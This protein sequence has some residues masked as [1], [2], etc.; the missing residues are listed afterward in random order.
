MNKVKSLGLVTLD[1]YD[2]EMEE[3]VQWLLSVTKW[4]LLDPLADT[5]VPNVIVTSEV[6]DEVLPT[7]LPSHLFSSSCPKSY[8]LGMCM[9]LKTL[10]G[11]IIR[12]KLSTSDKSSLI[13]GVV[14]ALKSSLSVDEGKKGNESSLTN[15]HLDKSSDA[16]AQEVLSLYGGGQDEL[17]SAL[18]SSTATFWPALQCFITLLERLEGQLWEHCSWSCKEVVTLITQNTHY[19]KE[20]RKLMSE[21]CI[22]VASADGT[23]GEPT[24]G[25]DTVSCSQLVYEW[26]SV[27]RAKPKL[28]T[29]QRTHGTHE[30]V[31]QWLVPFVQ[32][33]VKYGSL[34]NCKKVDIFADLLSHLLYRYK[35]GV[36]LSGNNSDG[37]LDVYKLCNFSSKVL[38]YNFRIALILQQANLLSPVSSTHIHT[39]LDLAAMVAIGAANSAVL[40]SPKMPFSADQ[41]T[42]TTTYPEC[43]VPACL[44]LSALFT[45]HEQCSNI[46]EM[47][48]SLCSKVLAV[49]SHSVF[50]GYL[51][52]RLL[53]VSSPQLSQT[54]S[55]TSP[56]LGGVDSIT[57]LC[58]LG[59]KGLLARLHSALKLKGPTLHFNNSRYVR[60]YVCLHVS[61]CVCSLNS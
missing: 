22:T 40:A 29:N 36:R 56:V 60:V 37:F 38:A 15:T 35:E 1:E 8:W 48:G 49:S 19:V 53:M 59:L 45:K 13:S 57:K 9:L 5:D 39:T 27:K 31:F 46:V 32:S 12:T 18:L 7:L 55:F 34:P 52:P 2:G 54:C 20:V 33:V 17:Q 30:E 51:T 44:L 26:E 25:S 43:A 16:S 14:G 23:D 58:N 21:G 28:S 61:T 3:V 4:G 10:E 6:W 42:C 47:L 50:A 11:S 24:S 41:P